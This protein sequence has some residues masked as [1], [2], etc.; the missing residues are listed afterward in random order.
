MSEQKPSREVNGIV[1][2]AQRQDC[3]EAQIWGRVL[4]QWK[5]FG[6]NKTLPKA[7]RQPNCAIGGE[8]FLVRG[9]TKN[10]MVTLRESSRVPLRRWESLPE[11]Q[12]SSQHSNNQAFMVEWPDGSHSLGKRHMTAR[13]EFAKRHVK[14]LRL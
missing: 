13:L 1:R 5:K 10:P 6:T 12:Q 4:I 14:T 2:R 3:V 8:G 11:G 7:G 9:V